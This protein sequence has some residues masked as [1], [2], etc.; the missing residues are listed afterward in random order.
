MRQH[1]RQKACSR[2]CQRFDVT[3]YLSDWAPNR[4]FCRRVSEP[5]HALVWAVPAPDGGRDF[6]VQFVLFS[7]RR[8]ACVRG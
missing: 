7:V 6:G 3:G 2:V 1:A 8:G 5:I 4:L